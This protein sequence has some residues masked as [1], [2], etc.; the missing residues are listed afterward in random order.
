MI[1]ANQVTPRWI[2]FFNN[3]PANKDMLVDPCKKPIALIYHQTH[4]FLKFG[5][6]AF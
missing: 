3:V 1:N 5:L 4:T 2:V 6:M